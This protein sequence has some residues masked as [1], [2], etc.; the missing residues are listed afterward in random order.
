MTNL[1]VYSLLFFRFT[2]EDMAP[3]FAPLGAN[4]AVAENEQEKVSHVCSDSG[5]WPQR[6]RLRDRCGR[7]RCD[8]A[9]LVKGFKGRP[10]P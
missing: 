4:Y 3:P 10:Y 1:F 5:L 8:F 6:G 2:E 9:F 7:Q